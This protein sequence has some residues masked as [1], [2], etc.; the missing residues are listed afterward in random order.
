MWIYMNNAFLSIVQNDSVPVILLVRARRSGDVESVFP[1]AGVIETSGS[2]YAF[3]PSI[4]REVVIDRIANAVP[5]I[6]YPNFK[7]SVS[8]AWSR[9]IYSSVWNKTLEGFDTG[10]Y[11]R[12]RSRVNNNRKENSASRSSMATKEKSADS[13]TSFLPKSA[14]PIDDRDVIDLTGEDLSKVD[15]VDKRSADNNTI[16]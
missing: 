1:D 4:S 14:S 10:M 11:S 12:R 15:F 8:N 5:S 7:D 3:R 9:G 13:T 2:Y 16:K 6:D